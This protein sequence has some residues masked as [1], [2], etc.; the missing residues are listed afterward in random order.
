MYRKVG[1]ARSSTSPNPRKN[2]RCRLLTSKH[3]RKQPALHRMNRL[4]MPTVP[5]LEAAAGSRN[6][7]AKE[8]VIRGSRPDSGR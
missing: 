7:A 2:L 6:A 3:A 1:A 4:A 8:L 5:R